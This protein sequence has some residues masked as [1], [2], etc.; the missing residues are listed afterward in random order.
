MK[1]EMEMQIQVAEQQR[2]SQKDLIDAAAK[3]DDLRL[4]QAEIAARTE[5]ESARL[6]VDIQKHRAEM[7]ASQLTEG[8]KMGLEI[9]RSRDERER[10]DREKMKPQE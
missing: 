10:Q 4:R 1:A 7:E 8:A 5:L 2:R 9:A 3:E 6:G